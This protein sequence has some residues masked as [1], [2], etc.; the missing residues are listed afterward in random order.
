[1][2]TRQVQVGLPMP[3]PWTIPQQ[4]YSCQAQFLL[5]HGTG[6]S[7]PMAVQEE[8]LSAFN[9]DK[10]NRTSQVSRKTDCCLWSSGRP[11]SITSIELTE[12]ELHLAQKPTNC[13][14]QGKT[15]LF[16][17]SPPRCH[18]R[19]ATLPATV[20]EQPPAH[21][22]P[23]PSLLPCT[24]RLYIQVQAPTLLWTTIVMTSCV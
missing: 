21:G 12:R 16:A 6:P 18:R 10:C 4:R 22:P 7:K 8:A 19:S 13:V 5:L 23:S 24:S 1:M 15:R 11:Q 17:C 3:P 2:A 20:P 9:P 14:S